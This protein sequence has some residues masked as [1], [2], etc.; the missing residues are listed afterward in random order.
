[1][2]FVY[3]TPPNNKPVGAYS[4]IPVFG[5]TQFVAPLWIGLPVQ[6][7]G[8]VYGNAIRRFARHD[9]SVVN[10]DFDRHVTHESK[11]TGSGAFCESNSLP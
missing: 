8:L 1:M 9:P 7:C 6:W 2:P 10:L 11:F 3:L 5:A 4:T